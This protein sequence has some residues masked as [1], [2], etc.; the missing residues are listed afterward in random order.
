MITAEVD[1]IVRALFWGMVLAL[2]YDSIRIFRRVI[3]HYHIWT[4]SLEDI[5]FWINVGF[6]VFAVTYEANDGIVRGFLVGGFVVGALVFRYS[7]STFYVRYVSRSII[8]ILKP[9]KKAA[10]MFKM[11]LLRK[12]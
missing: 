11:L 6:T 1:T 10:G 8:F 3:R 9:L 4:M 12:K 5:L 2:E 7:F